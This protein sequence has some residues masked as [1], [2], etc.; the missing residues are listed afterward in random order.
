MMSG[1]IP[2]VTG[3]MQATYRRFNQKNPMTAGFKIKAVATRKGYRN[4]RF[5]SRKA[6]SEIDEDEEYG[7]IKPG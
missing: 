1:K 6:E 7:K 3:T 4:K 2:C 5:Y